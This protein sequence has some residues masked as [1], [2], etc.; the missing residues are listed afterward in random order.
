MHFEARENGGEG[1]EKEG[2]RGSW[3]NFC[4]QKFSQALSKNFDWEM[5]FL[6][7]KKVHFKVIFF[8][9]KAFLVR[10]AKSD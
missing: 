5:Y 1:E 6:S 7:E 10:Y 2:E 3:E 9:R 8:D 4:G